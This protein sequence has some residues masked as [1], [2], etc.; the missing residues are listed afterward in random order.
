MRSARGE[1]TG[2]AGRPEGCRGGEASPPAPRLGKELPVLLER[3]S[4]D[5]VRHGLDP[6]H[7]AAL[8]LL[9]AAVRAA[10]ATHEAFLAAERRYLEALRRATA[11]RR[12]HARAVEAGEAGVARY[13][14]QRE[15]SSAARLAIVAGVKLASA[16]KAAD[17][18]WDTLVEV[19]R[20]WS[21]AMAGSLYADGMS[22][23]DRTT[24]DG[25]VWSAEECAFWRE[26]FH[27]EPPRLGLPPEPKAFVPRAQAVKP[28]KAPPF[29]V[30]PL[31]P[32]R[33]QVVDLRRELTD[34]LVAGPFAWLS[35]ANTTLRAMAEREGVA[36]ETE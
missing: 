5:A 13:R 28:L 30:W 6:M 32:G 12:E 4:E 22:P 15:S 10:Q 14:A 3:I 17:E 31:N 36:V 29:E 21:P 8:V 25:E 34:R 27:V 20:E 33:W 19:A 11:R 9:D 2:G 1:T 24:E 7:A 23:E 16:H 26:T 35:E 18:A